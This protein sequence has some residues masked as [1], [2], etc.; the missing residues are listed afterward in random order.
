MPGTA[1]QE[2][3]HKGIVTARSPVLLEPGELQRADDCVYKPFDP[4]IHQVGGRTE[5]NSVALGDPSGIRG[6]T[7]LTF[8]GQRTDQLVAY[9]KDTLYNSDYTAA[10]GTFAKT[11]GMGPVAACSSVSPFTTITTTT[12]NGFANMLKGALVFG[13]NVQA[14]TRVLTIPDSTSITITQAL[15][16]AISG[17]TLAFSLGVAITGNNDNTEILDYVQW[18]SV[19]FVAG[20]GGG[21]RRLAWTPRTSVDTTTLAEVFAG[22]FAGMTPVTQFDASALSVVMGTWNG[23]LGIGTYWFLI[24]EVINPGQ[25]DEVESTYLVG[26]SANDPKS[27]ITPRSATITALSQG[28]QITFPPVTND[29]TLS[30]RNQATHW[31]VYM[32]EKTLNTSTSPDLST[33]KRVAVVPVQD[34]TVTIGKIVVTY[35]PNVPTTTALGPSGTGFT[36]PGFMLTQNGAAARGT[37]RASDT[38]AKET[39]LGSFGLGAV[40]GTIRGIEVDVRC[41]M[42]Y[43]GTGGFTANPAD[44]SVTLVAG[45]KE[46]IPYLSKATQGYWQ[47]IILGGKSDTWGRTWVASDF[48]DGTFKVLVSKLGY[49]GQE[50]S[51][52]VD[53]LRVKVYTGDGV[54]PD[55]LGKSFQVVTYRS[56]IGTT[57]SDPAN[58]PPPRFPNTMEVFQGQLV[59]NNTGEEAA[60]VYSLPGQPE[61]FPKPYKMVFNS[62]KKDTVTCIKR[63]GQLL[64]VGLKNSVKRVNYLPTE[65]DT[66]FKDGPAHE[67]LISDE[68]I[69]GPLAATLMDLPGG[70]VVLPFISWTGLF[71]TDGITVRPLN[72]DLDWPNIVDLANL[73]T[74]I[75]RNYPKQK[76]L[77]LFYAPSGTSHGKNTRALVFCYSPD[78]I[79]EGGTLPAIGPFKVSGRSAASVLLS[80]DARLLTGH[81][82]LGKVY[83]EDSG[84]SLPAGYT[85]ANSAGTEAAITTSPDIISRRFYSAGAG[86]MTREQRAYIEHDANGITSTVS[87]TF[88]TT[89]TT[90]TSAAGFG[91]ITAGMYVTGAGILPGTIVTA[92]T[93]SSTL[94]I[95]QAP[96]ADGTSVTLTFHT[97][98]LSA[99]WRGQN[100]GEG[101]QTLETA[102]LPMNNGGLIVYHPD[103]VKQALELR[104][105][106]V[107]LPNGNLTDTAP[108]MRLHYMNILVTDG[109]QET[110]L[111]SY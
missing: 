52:E 12:P 50:Q 31:V 19:Y 37:V 110:N 44:F 80:G 3:F 105:S 99:S 82:S 35:G 6:L 61:Y 46:S 42:T 68:G 86:R 78:K 21:I 63:V 85:V 77:V 29:G 33:F 89:S 11:T 28:V 10:T 24:T 41:E 104:L 56:Q 18:N 91:T 84:T 55:S 83:V 4:A 57:V 87:S 107:L 26:T 30:E 51:I 45:T 59:L 62:K 66:D 17:V 103:N 109:G 93:D 47:N 14:G 15:S 49:S 102:Y 101:L 70:G 2:G 58:L 60:I 38:V 5:Y 79:K 27:T 111:A 106:K 92:K 64:V 94:T 39:F 96:E 90:V 69:V 9:A 98:T 81:E 67:D 1:Q 22:R 43:K 65:T 16:G 8:D 76:W 71:V 74:C 97:G 72:N 40:S 48:V 36:N 32:S 75:L 100:I 13:T 108:S 88:V 34:T 53:V 95:S 20:F 23:D 54:V 73:D 7:H 25:P